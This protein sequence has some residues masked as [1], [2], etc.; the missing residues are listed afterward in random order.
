[1]AAWALR[2]SGELNLV[3]RLAFLQHSNNKGGGYFRKI[4]DGGRAL[5]TDST[6]GN[7]TGRHP[8]RFAQFTQSPNCG[9]TTL[10][11]LLLRHL[12]HLLRLVLFYACC[13]PASRCS[14]VNCFELCKLMLGDGHTLVSKDGLLCLCSTH[15]CTLCFLR[16]WWPPHV[17]ACSK[18]KGLVTSLAQPDPAA[19]IHT[20]PGL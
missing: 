5:E 1:M 17:G 6:G 19:A 8:L 18:R 7:P 14:P 20:C 11:T 2:S 16:W 3:P 9:D 4:S 15:A 12:C 10:E 13:Q